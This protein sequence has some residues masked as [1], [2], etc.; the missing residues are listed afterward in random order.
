MLEKVRCQSHSNPVG[1][2][3]L[4]MAAEK[5]KNS[6][7]LLSEWPMNLFMWINLQMETKADLY[8]EMP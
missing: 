1:D 5:L 4:M 6:A 3:K 2:T 7:K 8:Q